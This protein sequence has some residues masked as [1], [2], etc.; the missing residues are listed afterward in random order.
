MVGL[1]NHINDKDLIKLLKKSIASLHG[2]PL[3]L[4]GVAK[5][6]GGNVGFLQFTDREQMRIFQ[7]LFAS[8]VFAQNPKYKLKEVTKKLNPRDFI[9]VKNES[10]EK[11]EEER[12]KE[13]RQATPEEIAEEMKVPVADRVTPYHR[14]T[15]EEQI[16]KKRD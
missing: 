8:E 10:E 9:K 12:K 15:Y 1:P 16:E 3:P 6:R 14:F 11:E 7:D 13:A 4:K 2:K 5:K